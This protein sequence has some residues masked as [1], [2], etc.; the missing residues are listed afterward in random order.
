MGRGSRVSTAIR[1]DV[2]VANLS[3]R[4]NGG[5]LLLAMHS[6]EALH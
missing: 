5:L 3:P 6:T 1:V 2:V 4:K